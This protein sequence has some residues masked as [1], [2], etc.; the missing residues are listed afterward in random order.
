MPLL[1]RWP[2][3]G[4]QPRRTEALASAI[5]VAPT[6]L[7]LAGVP[8]AATMQG[9]SLVPVLKDP[10]A[11]VRDFVFAEHNWHNF[12]AHIRLV[13]AG[14]DVYMRNA[15]PDLPLTG[16]R[17]DPCSEALRVVR[18]AGKATPLQENI[19]IAPRPAEE[20]Y[21]LAADPVQARNLVGTVDARRLNHM[22]ALLDRWTRETGDSV[23]DP[24]VRT[25]ADV[26]YVTGKK[27]AGFQ[28]GQPPGATARALQI[29]HPG[30][31]R[32]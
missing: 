2:Q 6:I 32:E 19:F 4:L 13:R 29:N 26:D 28:R 14:R 20:F 5:D 3:V 31:V 12:M 24:A 22:R 23:P 9:V 17:D 11:T 8:K 15:W 27:I 30:P 25:P 18:A 16:R 7:E 21:D 10:R 1:V